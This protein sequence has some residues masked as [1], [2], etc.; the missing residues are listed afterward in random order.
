VTG[1]GKAKRRLLKLSKASLVIMNAQGRTVYRTD[2]FSRGQI[3]KGAIN[4]VK[5]SWPG[6][7]DTLDGTVS[8]SVVI[9]PEVVRRDFESTSPGEEPDLIPAEESGPRNSRSVCRF[10][11]A[12]K[13]FVIYELHVGS[14]GSGRPRRFE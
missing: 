12:S 1:F 11:P 3:G 7:V 8:C 9:D 2:I 10:P 6:T 14:L 13:T 4:P 5:A